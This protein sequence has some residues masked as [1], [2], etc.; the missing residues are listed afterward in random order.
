MVRAKCGFDSRFFAALKKKLATKNDFQRHGILVFDEM[1][2]RKEVRVHSKT[3]T[4]SGYS[5]FGDIEGSTTNELADH[6]LVLLFVR[7]ETITLNQL[8]LLQAKGPLRAQH[9]PSWF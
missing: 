1:Q 4:Y 8:Q 5:D 3:M 9:S 6:G 7:L 2:V